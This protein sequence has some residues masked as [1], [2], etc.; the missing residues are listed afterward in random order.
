MSDIIHYKTRSEL[1][2]LI[3]QNGNILEIGVF[4]GD[5]SK[6]IIEIAKPSSLYL[7]DIWQGKYGSGDKDGNNHY[8]IDD[9]EQVYLHLYEK[10][11]SNKNTHIIRAS[12]VAFLKSCKDNFFDAIYID[13]DHTAQAVYNDL[14]YSHQKIK[15]GG[16]IMGHDYHYGVEYAVSVFC[17]Q[18]SQKV[19]YIADDGCP[20]FFIEISK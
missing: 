7:V 9:M 10:Y 17:E 13:G 1:L 20:S 3:P 14:I 18:L 5:F 6:E 16:I 8:D 15:N 12:S 19:K 11:K 4:V 2:H